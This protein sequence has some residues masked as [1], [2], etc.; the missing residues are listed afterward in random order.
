MKQS[1]M[2]PLIS[3]LRNRKELDLCEME[4]RLVYIVSSKL[5][6]TLS[7]L[8]LQVFYFNMATPLHIWTM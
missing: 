2:M 5:Q 8:L 6:E 3:A 1:V 7:Q 4:A